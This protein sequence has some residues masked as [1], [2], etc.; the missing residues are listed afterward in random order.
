MF[1]RMFEQQLCYGSDSEEVEHHF[2][3]IYCRLMKITSYFQTNF[4]TKNIQH[5]LKS[6]KNIISQVY[7]PK[8]F[9]PFSAH[10]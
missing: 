2:W 10:L 4:N 7:Q 3:K 1:S 5:S 8:I 9:I 6:A